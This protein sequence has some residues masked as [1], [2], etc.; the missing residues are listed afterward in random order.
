MPEPERASMAQRT[1]R[2][3]QSY[4]ISVY[5]VRSES[6]TTTCSSTDVSDA[7]LRDAT[8]A[9]MRSKSPGRRR[10]PSPRRRSPSPSGR[11]IS[12][13]KHIRS[14]SPSK[15]SAKTDL[16]VVPD[17]LPSPPQRTFSEAS[18]DRPS[19]RRGILKR[20]T[21]SFRPEKL[22]PAPKPEPI[23]SFDI[24]LARATSLGDNMSTD[25]PPEA[26][27]KT[28]ADDSFV[29]LPK[30]TVSFS[31][32][33]R[34]PNPKPSGVASLCLGTGTGRRVVSFGTLTIFVCGLSLRKE[35]ICLHKNQFATL[36]PR[37]R[38]DFSLYNEFEDLCYDLTYFCRCFASEDGEAD[39]R[40]PQNY[41]APTIPEDDHTY[42]DSTFDEPSLDRS[43]G[44]I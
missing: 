22:A 9:S 41:Y 21:Y 39:R 36:Q 43:V 38:L 34:D 29:M 27:G 24:N 14:K 31:K 11:S 3:T 10:S 20:A 40:T 19:P 2:K 18:A 33:V 15:T 7:A 16:A 12:P 5:E 28:D 42:D 6:P 8:L 1:Q 23:A 35:H 32:D 30:R 17:T 4:R 26:T 13:L 37:R 25:S 44:S